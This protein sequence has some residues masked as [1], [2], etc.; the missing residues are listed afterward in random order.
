M[1]EVRTVRK[2]SCQRA[3]TRKRTL[4]YGSAL[5]RGDLRLLEDS[6]ERRGSLGSDSVGFETASEGWGGK[7]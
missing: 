4:R 3:L 1:G 2:Q 5:E 6:S 7:W